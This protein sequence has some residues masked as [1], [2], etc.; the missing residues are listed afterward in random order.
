MKNFNM[1]IDKLYDTNQLHFQI[2]WWFI[3]HLYSKTF[4]SMK[5]LEFLVN[6]R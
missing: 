4:L 2:L 5:I 6:F 3:M 1:D